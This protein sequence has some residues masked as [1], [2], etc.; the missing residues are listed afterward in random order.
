ME[1]ADD[2]WINAKIL[3]YNNFFGG[4]VSKTATL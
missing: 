4:K 1:V 2:D 3:K